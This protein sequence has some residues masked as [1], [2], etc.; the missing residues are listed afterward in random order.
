M[1]DDGSHGNKGVVT[2]ALKELIES[3][4]EYDEV[5]TIG[6][7]VMM[8]FVSALTKEYGIKPQ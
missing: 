3:G 5:I 1:T 2:V 8:K 4:E 7:L 6:P